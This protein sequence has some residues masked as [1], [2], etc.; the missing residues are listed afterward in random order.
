M[1]MNYRSPFTVL[2][3]FTALFYSGCAGTPI[4]EGVG[5]GPDGSIP[6]PAPPPDSPNCVSSFV[7]PGED[8]IHGILPIPRGNLDILGAQNRIRTILESE[9]RTEILS[10]IPGYLHAV[11]YT[12]VWKFPDDVEFWFPPDEALIHFRS[13]ARLGKGDMGVN[14]KRM[15]R[16]RTAFIEA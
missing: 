14:R 13:A 4:P 16:I 8:A 11:Q 3:L 7:D 5:V 10:D 1:K 2:V 15:E 12:K 6:S 9:E